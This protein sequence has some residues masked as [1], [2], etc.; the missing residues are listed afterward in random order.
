MCLFLKLVLLKTMYAGPLESGVQT[1]VACSKELW[2]DYRVTPTNLTP[3]L[4]DTIDVC[5]RSTLVAFLWQ[6]AAVDFRFSLL[7]AH[8]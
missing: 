2:S 6:H 7:E 1:Q 5:N 8:T 4:F 3:C